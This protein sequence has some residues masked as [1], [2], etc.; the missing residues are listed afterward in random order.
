M[1]RKA[2]S[3]SAKIKEELLCHQPLSRHCMLAQLR[4]MLG[5]SAT[6]TRADGG[7]LHLRF[8]A[9]NKEVVRKCFTLW[10][11]T[12]NM[13]TDCP[14]N[15][16]INASTYFE[17]PI[18]GEER[19]QFLGERGGLDDPTP[20]IFLKNACCRR[21]FLRG[22]FLCIGSLS[23]PN[24][25]YHLEFVCSNAAKAEQLVEVMRTFGIEAKTVLRKKYFVVYLKDASDI[26]DL[27][28]VME[29]PLALME[30]EN[31]RI[32]KDVRN[33][34]NRRVNCEAANISKTVTASARQVEDILYVQK[35]Y[36]FAKLPK[37][38]RETAQL[39]L[40]YTDCSLKE[41]GE[42]LQPVVGKSG[43]NHRLR[44]LSEL[45]EEIRKNEEGEVNE[46]SSDQHSA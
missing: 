7:T 37:H 21:S 30:L 11:K 25:S 9:E 35:H 6:L 3:F 4:A 19:S 42:Y 1:D 33:G 13:G 2:R 32:V 38:L 17:I 43:I 26:V 31:L 41:L 15:M 5:A 22:A 28:S 12:Y 36:G 39:R 8:H 40:E 23:D 27:L 18:S 46:A 24:K 45:A 44:K 10:E 20:S 16:L 34:V 14:E 29:A